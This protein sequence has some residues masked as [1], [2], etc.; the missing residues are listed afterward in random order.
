[1][2]AALHSPFAETVVLD[3]DVCVLR[4]TLHHFLQPLES[5]DITMVWECCVQ[6]PRP[7]FGTGWEPNTGVFGVSRRPNSLRLLHEWHS[8]F[9]SHPSRYLAFSSKDQQAL[10]AVLMGR[11]NFSFLP[12]P[13]AFNFRTFT[14]P[15][16]PTDRFSGS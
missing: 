8:E 12:L 3:L 14:M 9:V 4:P 16:G 6:G 13:A 5:F 10:L 2:V 11:R 1:M 7:A 15:A